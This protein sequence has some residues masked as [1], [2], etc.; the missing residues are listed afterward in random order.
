MSEHFYG[1][2]IDREKDQEL[3][4]QVLNKYKGNT[5]NDKL[6]E[7]IWNDL[8]SLKHQGSLKSHF[9]VELYEDPKG[10]FPSQVKVYL[11]SKV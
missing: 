10:I 5:P 11:E 6:K 1:A 4:Q 2:K 3:V 7:L 8:S 9:K